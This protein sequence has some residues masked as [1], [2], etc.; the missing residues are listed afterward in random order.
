[1]VSY[2]FKITKTQGRDYNFFQ[3]VTVTW[4]QF[5]GGATD[6]YSPDCII[7]LPSSFSS[8]WL[9]NETGSTVVEV[10]YN[11]YTVHDELNPTILPQGAQYLNR[12]GCSLI[13]LR[14]KTGAS[15][16]VSIR[17]WGVR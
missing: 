4:N 16:T 8:L 14:L 2:P 6:G 5:G 12:P 9:I 7:T 10:S 13:W 17:A 11:G 1:M 3:K 15:A